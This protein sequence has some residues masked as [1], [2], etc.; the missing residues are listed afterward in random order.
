MVNTDA[1]YNY[2]GSGGLRIWVKSDTDDPAQISLD[3]MRDNARNGQIV[4]SNGPY[5]EATFRETGSSDAPVIA[6]QDLAAESKKVTA[7][8]KVQ[9]PNWFDI[10]TVI[11]LVNGRRHDNLTFSRDT[12]PD[13]FGKDAVKFAHDVDIELREDAH[14]IVLTGHRTQLIGDVMGP[15][16]GAQHPTALNNP[17]FVD[18]DGDGFQANKDTLDIPLPVKFVAEDKR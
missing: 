8:I 16:W 10:D 2:H 4:M 6:G 18:I 15:M 14:L 3:E 7:S 9:C 1:H 12:H 5:L 11:V 13:M 17:V